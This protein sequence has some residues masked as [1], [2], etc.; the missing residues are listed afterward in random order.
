[1]GVLTWERLLLRG[2]TGLGTLSFYV[3][4]S[5]SYACR[6]HLTSWGSSGGLASAAA[7]LRPRWAAF[8]YL[9]DDLDL[10]FFLVSNGL[11]FADLLGLDADHLDQFIC[12]LILLL[13]LSL[14]NRQLRF[15]VIHLG[16]EKP[17]NSKRG[18]QPTYAALHWADEGW[19][20]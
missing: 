15:Q 4:L 18:P 7:L 20:P 9:I 12:T 10:D 2:P 19:E 3:S 5:L 13:E 16:K 17:R 14:L 6:W 8:T 11:L 1:M